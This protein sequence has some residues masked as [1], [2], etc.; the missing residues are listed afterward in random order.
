[1]M[2]KRSQQPLL[3]VIIPTRNRAKYL[4]RALD[5]L[6]RCIDKEFPNTEV[7]VIDGN[8][9]D[10]TVELL[11]SYGNRITKW[12]SEPDRSVGEAVN[13]GIALSEGRILRFTGDDDEILPGGLRTLTNLLV[14]SKM[15][16]AIVGQNKVFIEDEYGNTRF[17][18]QK[19]LVG[20]VTL[21]K[22]WK[23]P[24]DGIFIPEC[25]FIWRW[26]MENVGGYD[27][28]FRYFG[29][30][31]NFFRLVKAGV[32]I[33]VVPDII[34]NTYQT[35]DSDS[36]KANGSALW[37]AE[38]RLVKK[39]HV[40]PYWRLWHTLGGEVSVASVLK[41][42]VRYPSYKL[43]GASPRQLIGL[44]RSQRATRVLESTYAP[45]NRRDER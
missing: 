43:F 32:K 44:R 30:V 4:R 14:S 22:L 26:A 29:Y 15:V 24:I 37:Q 13:K 7:V 41:Q 17:Y 18:P 34:L 40:P 10:G 39:R 28:N 27:V 42:V 3:S 38:W 1:M 36:I 20:D 5:S 21:E 8:S 11:K 9:D 23:F 6:I 45:S 25:M 12:I 31:D 33:R 16:D 2:S 35:P 19:K